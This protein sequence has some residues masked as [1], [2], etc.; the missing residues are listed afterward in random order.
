[1]IRCLIVDDS[2][3]FRALMRQI[4][5]TAPGVMVVG[6]AENADQAVKLTLSLRPTVVTMDV[7]MP[8]RSGIDAV[9]EIMKVQ[10]TPVIVVC[11][12][13]ADESLGIA[14]RALQAGALEVL[15]KPQALPVA[16]FHARCEAI[17][18]AVRAVAGLLHPLR[19]PTSL[20]SPAPA[21]PSAVA[22]GA[23]CV[24]VVTS[25]GGPPALH[26]LL[27]ALPASF[28]APLLIVQ[29]LAEGVVTGLARWLDESSALD[30][31]VAEAG[32]VIA[33]GTALLA[34]DGVHLCVSRGRVRFDSGP[35]GSGFRPSGSVLLKS[36]AQEYGASAAGVVLTGMGDDGAAGLRA[37]RD[38]GGF[39][40]AQGPTSSVV[41]GMPQAAID[42][43]AAEVIVELESI[44]ATL[45][46]A[47]RKQPALWP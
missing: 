2:P 26:R 20:R 33:P 5:Q 34:P 40:V 42:L 1:M 23:R 24:G 43:G 16:R 28:E 15:E 17:R 3:S 46:W 36:L 8:G 35:K 37:L 18:L 44:P 7:Q 4:L 45:E 29:H 39:T 10:P 47:A 38:C 22:R 19:A 25:T 9:S 13:G 6:E 21:A 11:S 12:G 30:V 31:R 14:F 32:E 41:F 27:T